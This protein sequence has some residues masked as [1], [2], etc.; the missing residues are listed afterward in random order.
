MLGVRLGCVVAAAGLVCGGAAAQGELAI[1]EVVDG[2]VLNGQPS[3]VQLTN[4]GPFGIVDLSTY[5]IGTFEDG[6]TTLEGGSAVQLDPVALAPGDSYVVSYEP[7]GNTDCSATETCF[8]VAYFAPPDQFSGRL[9]DGNDAVALFLGNAVGDG[10]NAILVDVYGEIGVDGT[11]A[12]W[13]YT[14]SY[15]YRCTNQSSSVWLECDWFVDAPGALEQGNAAINLVF[16][17]NLTTP[18]TKVNCVPAPCEATSYCQAST[19]TNGCT[20]TLSGSAPGMPTGQAG[21]YVVTASGVEQDVNG[22]FFISL[23]GAANITTFFSGGTLCVRPPVGRTS[24]GTSG[25]AAACDGQLSVV[26]NDVT[27]PWGL[28][29]APGTSMWVQ[30]FYRDPLSVS[31]IGVSDGFYMI[32]E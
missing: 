25:G 1:T 21:D 5:S 17:R 22:L 26:V 24:I 30:G 29:T 11:G 15:A 23:N 27:K 28:L 9:F 13:D 20:A 32:F 18:F 14:D 16:M 6:S 7:S 12:T 3:W 2:T 8:Q 19:S 4:V 31:G 10:A